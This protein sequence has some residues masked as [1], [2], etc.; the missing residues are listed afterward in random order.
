MLNQTVL[1][2]RWKCEMRVYFLRVTNYIGVDIDEENEDKVK[3]K[4]NNLWKEL[5]STKPEFRACD[6][7]VIMT[8]KQFVSPETVAKA[9][10]MPDIFDLPEYHYKG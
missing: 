7:I 3:A 1:L 6:Q 8:E 5:V 2:P 10:D 9:A 4:A